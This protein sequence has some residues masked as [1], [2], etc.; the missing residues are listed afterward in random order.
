MYLLFLNLEFLN[1]SQLYLPYFPYR[2]NLVLYLIIHLANYYLRINVSINL[3][4]VILFLLRVFLIS[5]SNFCSLNVLYQDPILFFHIGFLIISVIIFCRNL[6][7]IIIYN[8]RNP[9]Q[10]YYSFM[11]ILDIFLLLIYF[12][13]PFFDIFLLISNNFLSIFYYYCQVL[14]LFSQVFHIFMHYFLFVTLIKRF[15]YSF[16]LINRIFLIFH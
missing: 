15:S 8:L 16:V 11:L 4:G 5:N 10:E 12:Y 6:K 9:F 14:Y 1:L 3:L 2:I 7:L 13:L